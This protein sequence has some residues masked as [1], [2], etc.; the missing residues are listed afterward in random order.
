MTEGDRPGHHCEHE[1]CGERCQRR[2]RQG[3][4]GALHPDGHGG[5]RQ[6]LRDA[7]EST[8]LSIPAGDSGGTIVIKVKGDTLDEP[9]ETII[10]TL[11]APTNATV[12]GTEGAGAATGTIN[13][14]DGNADGDA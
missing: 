13:D 3:G 6:R 8:S 4:H 12:S 2:V 1:F 14:D 5:G 7:G 11:G 10:V 9:N